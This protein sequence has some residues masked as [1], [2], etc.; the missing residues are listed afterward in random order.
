M[1]GQGI[2]VESALPICLLW[3][4]GRVIVLD[5]MGTGVGRWAGVQ[6]VLGGGSKG[7]EFAGVSNCWDCVGAGWFVRA[8]CLHMSVGWL[9][10][11]QLLKPI[12]LV[13]IIFWV[14]QE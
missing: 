6:R 9:R 8:G 5:A 2:L 1:V 14:C 10:C 7:Q 11:W 3:G 13:S 4:F 12:N